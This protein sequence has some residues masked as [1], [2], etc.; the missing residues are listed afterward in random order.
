MDEKTIARFWSK[1]DKR[2]PAVRA[3]LG[4]C[5]LWTASRDTHGYGNFTVQGK[6]RLAHKLSF[7]LARRVPTRRRW[8]LHRCDVKTCVNPEHLY[9]GDGKAN[10]RDAR[11]RGRLKPPPSGV[12]HN[13]ARLNPDKVREVK[14]MAAAGIPKAQIARTFGVWPRAVWMILEG[15]SWKNVT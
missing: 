2:G 15:K 10:V 12:N 14:R 8:V 6:T 11:D 7:E 1:V 4:P 13:R 9:I 5:W 3:E